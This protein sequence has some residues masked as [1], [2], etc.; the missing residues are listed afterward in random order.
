MG[1]FKAKLI[2]DTKVVTGKCRLSY[3]HL[4]TKYDESGKY[5]CVLLID[6]DNKDT[7]SAV[8]RGIENAKEKGKS[9]KWKGKIPGNYKSP[10]HDGDD[11]PDREGYAGCYYLSAKNGNRRPQV[12]DLDREEIVDQEEIYAGCYVRAS[13]TFFPYDTNGNGVGVILNHIQKIAD[14]ESLGGDISS[15]D[16][17]FSDDE[18]D[19]DDLLG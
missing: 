19:D 2:G 8:K 7:L 4:F 10:L 11:V 14:G 1:K 9:E 18:E 5:Q 12:V 16:D 17:D 15:A 13:I 6:K 3:P